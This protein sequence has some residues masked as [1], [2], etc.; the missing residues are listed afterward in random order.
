MLYIPIHTSNDTA[1]NGSSKTSKMGMVLISVGRYTL[2]N[3]VE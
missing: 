3:K 1:V 2:C